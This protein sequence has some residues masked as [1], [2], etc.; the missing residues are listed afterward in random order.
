METI[1]IEVPAMFADHHV[2]EVRRI[3]LELAGVED[4][5]AS[6]AFQVV[7]VTYEP[8]KVSPE[9]VEAALDQAGYLGKLPVPA[10]SGKAVTDSDGDPTYFRHTAAFSQTG[11]TV[12]FGQQVE[13]AARPLWPCP[14]IGAVKTMGD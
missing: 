8:G 3:L 7:E 4:V 12:G 1:T 2:T 9:A 14:G 6:S 13:S 10:E 11:Q 5:Y